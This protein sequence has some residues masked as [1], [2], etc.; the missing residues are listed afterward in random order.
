MLQ[1]DIRP[2]VLGPNVVAVF[3]QDIDTALVEQVPLPNVGTTEC[4]GEA[5]A[6]VNAV[7]VKMVFV[8]PIV[9]DPLPM[10]NGPGIAVVEVVAR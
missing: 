10:F 5:L 9:K 2:W 4:L 6:K 3:K 8:D 7:A 1:Y